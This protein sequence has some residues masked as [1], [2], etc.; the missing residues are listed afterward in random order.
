MG[1]YASEEEE[2]R[3]KPYGTNVPFSNGSMEPDPQCRYLSG[4]PEGLIDRAYSKSEPNPVDT[5][6]FWLVAGIVVVVFAV[7]IASWLWRHLR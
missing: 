3:M 1:L 5:A 2:I 6:A 4:L 7:P